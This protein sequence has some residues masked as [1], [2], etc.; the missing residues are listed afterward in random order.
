MARDELAHLA[1]VTRILLGR[2]GRLDRHHKNPS[3]DS[4]RQLARKGEPTEILNRLLIAALIEVRSCERFSVLTAASA[5]VELAG[6][7]RALFSFRTW[8][9]QSLLLTRRQI[10][11]WGQQ[12]RFT[13]RRCSPRKDVYLR[14]R[15]RALGP[16]S[17]P[18]HLAKTRMHFWLISRGVN[19]TKLLVDVSASQN[20]QNSV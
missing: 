14:S 16:E 13:G 7:Y 3:A 1:Q 18:D 4:L 12:L 2:G 17:T 19:P 9:L 20:A 15:T 8:P 11:E 6:F 5:G 10:H